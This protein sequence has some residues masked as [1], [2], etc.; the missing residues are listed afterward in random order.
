MKSL[1]CKVIGVT[2]ESTE[3][4]ITIPRGQVVGI[5]IIR[6]SE[7]VQKLFEYSLCGN[8]NYLSYVVTTNGERFVASCPNLWIDGYGQDIDSARQNMFKNITGYL[9]DYLGSLKTDTD[10]MI[11]D[12][13]D[14]NC[15]KGVAVQYWKGFH[16][17]QKFNLKDS[18]DSLEKSAMLLDVN[19]I[20]VR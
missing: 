9:K 15:R 1:C 2:K 11:A 10:S 7:A 6:P 8:E 12:I 4:I 3:K 19:D 14:L 18:K 5:G 16:D 20:G 17:F 13:R